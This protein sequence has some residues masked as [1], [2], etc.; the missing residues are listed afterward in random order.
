MYSVGPDTLPWISKPVL[1]NISSRSRK[2]PMLLPYRL[3]DSGVLGV[4]GDGG[5][6]AAVQ[7]GL[8]FM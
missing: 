4:E 2:K 8:G 5:L 6:V 1:L 3:G 7:L